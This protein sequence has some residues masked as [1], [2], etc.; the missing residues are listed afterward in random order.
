MS[1][2]VVVGSGPNGLAAAI[3]LAHAGLAVTLVEAHDRPGGGAPADRADPARR[4]PRRLGPV[5]PAG[6]RPAELRPAGPGPPRPARA[7][8]EVDLAHPLDDGR[9]GVA[10]RDMAL[11]AASL[12]QD[13]KSWE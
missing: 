3:R 8:A 4:T 9:A 6:G 10:A 13:A 12:G 5:Q 2:A 1:T 11:T 7:G